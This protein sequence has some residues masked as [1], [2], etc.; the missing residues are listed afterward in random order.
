VGSEKQDFYVDE[1]LICSASDFFKIKYKK[2]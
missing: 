1:E 2:E